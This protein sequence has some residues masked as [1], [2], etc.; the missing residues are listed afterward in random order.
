[1]KTS[2]EDFKTEVYHRRD[3]KQIELK[4]RNKRILT[5]SIPVL[6]VVG[7]I[8]LLPI[9]P[10]RMEKS[11]DNMI[12]ED[13]NLYQEESAV[14]CTVSFTQNGN[15]VI[16]SEEDADSIL[17]IVW[18]K[19]SLHDE[20][21]EETKPQMPSEDGLDDS[22]SL[23]RFTVTDNLGRNTHYQLDGMLLIRLD[24]GEETLLTEEEIATIRKI[25][26][27]MQ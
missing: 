24:N 11:T 3:T 1:M 7:I 19:N 26:S 21:K 25:S 23:V 13:A 10:Q 5:F 8:G 27:K 16:L 4:K 20:F 17:T 14:R 2:F 22:P 9:L 6:L 12:A 18:N 15:T